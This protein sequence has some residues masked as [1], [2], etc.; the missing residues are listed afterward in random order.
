MNF[1]DS[2]GVTPN[3]GG[4]P[5]ETS[6]TQRPDAAATLTIGIRPEYLQVCSS[7]GPNRVP[8]I[9]T[10]AQD[11]GTQWMVQLQI[12]KRTAWSKIREM[13]EPCSV[14]PAFAYIPPDKCALYANDRRVA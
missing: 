5:I 4:V 2:D 9:V 1:L 14:G 6:S 8:A 7:P 13:R 11:Q 3:I 10:S 12:G